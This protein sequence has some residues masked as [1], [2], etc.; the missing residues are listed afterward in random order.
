N[1]LITAVLIRELY[2]M[3]D[4]NTGEYASDNFVGQVHHPANPAAKERIKQLVQRALELEEKRLQANPNDIDALYARGVTRA[5]FSLY[6]ALVERAWFSALR[7][8]VGAR[9]DHEKV[10]ELDR[11]YTDAKL[12]VG[13]HNYLMGSLPWGVKMA[14][15]MVGLRGR[16]EKGIKYL[17]EAAN[18]QGETSNDAKVVLMVFLRREHRYDEALSIAATMVAA[19]PQ[20]GLFVLEQANLLRAKGDSQAAAEKYREVWHAGK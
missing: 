15:A 7:N 20:N 17:Y 19:F 3:E 9:H 1:D 2:H 5:Q 8:A 6:T 11:N 12:V 18:A 4:M 10:V 14:V 13:A 16:R